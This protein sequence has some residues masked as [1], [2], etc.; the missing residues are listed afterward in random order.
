LTGRTQRA[1]QIEAKRGEEIG[2]DALSKVVGTS[3]AGRTA[4]L[5]RGHLFCPRCAVRHS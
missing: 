5:T 2:A 1:V 4:V 3:P